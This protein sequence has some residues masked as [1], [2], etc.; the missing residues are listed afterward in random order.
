MLLTTEVESSVGYL[1]KLQFCSELIVANKNTNYLSYRIHDPP[2]PP[3][4]THTHFLTGRLN[5]GTVRVDLNVDYI[6]F[7]RKY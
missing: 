3:T 4:H 5:V 7:I 6:S 2:P 1:L